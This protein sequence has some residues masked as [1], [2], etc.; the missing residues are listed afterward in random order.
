VGSEVDTLTKQIRG[1]GNPDVNVSVLQDKLF[2]MVDEMDTIDEAI[3]L[4]GNAKGFAEKIAFK[5]YDF[6]EASDGTAAG[7]LD[8]RRQL[9]RW[10]AKNSGAGYDVDIINGRNV[11]QTVIRREVNDA[12]FNAVPGVGVKNSLGKQS[13]LL[14]A[15][16]VMQDKIKLEGANMWS[17]FLKGVSEGTHVGPVGAMSILSAIGGAAGIASGGL[18]LAAGGAAT[19]AAVWATYAAATS[20]T[21]KKVLGQLINYTTKGI[22]QGSNVEQLRLDRLFLIDMLQAEP[23]EEVEEEGVPE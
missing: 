2:K 12:V 17:R 5:A 1:A 7:V 21:K 4:S 13:R 18:G 14:Q 22:K 3:T 19:G 6:L 16:E 15:S 9:D 23:K 10:V 8:A 11:A 20:A